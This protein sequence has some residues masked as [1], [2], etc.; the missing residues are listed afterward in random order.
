MDKERKAISSLNY[1][2]PLNVIIFSSSG[3]SVVETTV[4][5]PFHV[6]RKEEKCDAMLCEYVSREPV[7]RLIAL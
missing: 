4:R 6:K 7:L 5:L 3:M 2:L 1:T